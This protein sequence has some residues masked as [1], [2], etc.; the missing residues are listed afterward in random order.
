MRN[1]AS[2]ANASMAEQGP[3]VAF[4]LLEVCQHPLG[5][6]GVLA[7]LMGANAPTQVP[8]PLMHP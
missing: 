7:N 4:H 6:M 8:K 1:M 2:L 5:A 3:V